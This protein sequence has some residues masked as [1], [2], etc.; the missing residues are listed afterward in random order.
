[1]MRI[2]VTTDLSASS[3]AGIR[4]GIQ[5]AS[6]IPR[7]SL[8]F[9]H[10]IEIMKPTSW[11]ER[12]YKSY[13]DQRIAEMREELQRFVDNVYNETATTPGEHEFFLKVATDIGPET[14]AAAKKFRASLICLGTRGG[15]KIK[16]LLGSNASTLLS[17]SPKP[18]VVVPPGW[19][20]QPVTEVLYATDLENTTRELR[21]VLSFSGQLGA[22][23]TTCHYNTQ[24][25]VSNNKSALQAK[26]KKFSNEPNLVFD[27][28]RLSPGDSLAAALMKDIKKR[29]VQLLIMFTRQKRNWFSRLFS[30]SNSSAL[31]RGVQVPVLV[32][33]KK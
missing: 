10:F 21:Q 17:T 4:F 20:R 33:P 6:Q 1:M 18:V 24:L 14:L 23:V 31:A 29:G 25:A 2:L 13:S 15:G 16:K 30:P 32:Y 8:I 7:C 26:V 19:K 3:K 12:K 11:N 27:F 28:K 22:H 5:L 9:C